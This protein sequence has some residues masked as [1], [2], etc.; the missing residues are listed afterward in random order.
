[1]S[2]FYSVSNAPSPATRRAWSQIFG[3]MVQD[4]R[5]AIG[6][7][8]EEA[9][10]LSGLESSEWAAIEA[11]HVPADL[12]SDDGARLRSIAD[13]LEVRFDDMALLV[14]LCQGAWAS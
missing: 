2:M 3:G 4:R 10:H 11:G 1:L 7:S 5:E 13:A 12:V 9:A 6:R 14:Y 8:V